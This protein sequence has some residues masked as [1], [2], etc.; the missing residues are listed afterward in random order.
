MFVS[1]SFETLPDEIILHICQYLRGADVLFSFYNLNNRLNITITGYCRYVNLLSVSY[2]QFEY[3]V[4]HV[5]PQ[6]SNS[7]QTFLLN[8]NWETIISKKLNSI[9]FQSPMTLLFPQLQKLI[10]KW[11]TTEKLLLFIDTLHDLPQL[12]ELDIRFLKGKMLNSLL[13]KVL[14]TNN[15]QL[16]IVSFDHDSI[17]FDIC[18]DITLISYPNIEQLTVNLTEAKFMTNLFLLIPNIRCLYL[19]IEEMSTEIKCQSIFTNLPYL[20]HLIT[21]QLRSINLFWTLDQ[22]SHILKVMPSLQELTFDL[23][24]ED[25]RLINKENLLTILPR[26]LIKLEYFIRYYFSQLESEIE[27]TKSFSSPHFPVI[28][29][30]DEPRSRFII[31]TIPCNLHS[32]ILTGTVSQYM[33]SGWK[34]M[35]QTENLYIAHITS[36]L[37]ILHILQHF[38]R[39]RT[40]TIDAKDKSQILSLPL[41]SESINFKLPFL[42]QIEI[43]GIFE[44]FPLF[45]VAPNIDYMI[46]YFDCLKLLLNDESTCHLLQTQVVRLNIVNWEDIESDLIERISEIFCS[47]RHLVIVLKDSKILI[48]DFVLKVLSLWKGKSR[49]S[50]DIKGL[51]SKETS[52][53]LRQWIITHSHMREED[54]FAVECND[55][56]FDLWF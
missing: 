5:L 10:I 46:I 27:T 53:N 43:F 23:R 39:L 37:E 51:L 26:S 15:N 20:L 48:D 47:L 9:L 40:L 41:K 4:S 30:L 3:S 31:Y 45:N 25:K 7:V 8:G 1:S 13:T 38:R 49:L 19:S 22:I 34:Y 14:S 52:E 33:P 16:S 12:I 2:E 28:S 11:F 21:F 32:V 56:W 18:D 44:L 17:D 35:Q 6:I 24:T 54:S 29:M 55:N 42:K 36:V 50:I